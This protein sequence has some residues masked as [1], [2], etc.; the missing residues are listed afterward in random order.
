M[1]K[2]DSDGV[3]I[4]SVACYLMHEKNEILMENINNIISSEVIDVMAIMII[5]RIKRLVLDEHRFPVY[6]DRIG[7]PRIPESDRFPATPI[8]RE[9]DTKKLVSESRFFL[10]YGGEGG[11]R[12]LGTRL[13]YT[14]FPGVRLR[15]LGHLSVRDAKIIRFVLVL[16][17][18]QLI[19][20]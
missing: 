10:F 20:I 14:H 18:Q 19:T 15:P 1:H 13:G 2:T 3:L 8:D 4:A 7:R 9:T 17:C 12:T 11:I 5:C 6:S 16:Q